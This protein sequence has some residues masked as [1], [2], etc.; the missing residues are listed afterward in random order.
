[1][2][3][4]QTLKDMRKP[5]EILVPHGVKIK[6]KE[7]TGYS[8]VTIRFALKGFTDTES[9]KLIRKRAL[10]MGGVMVK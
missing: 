8:E 10:E 4:K 9:S 3:Q 1:M 5:K 7:S 2:I 6:L